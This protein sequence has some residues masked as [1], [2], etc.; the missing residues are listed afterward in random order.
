MRWLDSLQA[1]LYVSCA[2]L[3]AAKTQATTKQLHPQTRRITCRQNKDRQLVDVIAALFSSLKQ[4]D[5]F[6]VR[7]NP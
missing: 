7:P 3:P 6:S 2:S 4:K 5:H 1:G